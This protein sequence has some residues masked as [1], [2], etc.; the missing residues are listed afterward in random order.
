MYGSC[1]TH[2]PTRA[3]NMHQNWYPVDATH[4]SAAVSS[5]L[6]GISIIMVGYAN[7]MSK[8][9]GGG[10]TSCFVTITFLVKSERGCNYGCTLATIRGLHG[11][12]FINQL[13]V[14]AEFG[15]CTGGDSKNSHAGFF[16]NKST[17]LTTEEL[18]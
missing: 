12:S 8:M 10:Q 9:Y 16:G 13:L 4:H 2:G 6:P 18:Q 3:A 14:E 11:A 7:F 17:L 5:K 15:Q 1:G